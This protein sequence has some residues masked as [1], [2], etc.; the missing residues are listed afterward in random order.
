[1]YKALLPVFAA[2]W[3][4][5]SPIELIAQQTD[6]LHVTL[7][8]RL[9]LANGWLNP[10]T[11]KVGLRGD[12][13]PLTWGTTYLAEDKNHDSLYTVQI[14]F[15]YEGP[16]MQVAL[17]IKVDG[18]KNPDDGWQKG[19]N[20]LITLRKATT[21]TLQLS[22]NDEAAPPPPTLSGDIRIIK[23]FKSQPLQETRDLYI[24]LPP[25]YEKSNR[26]YPV[27]YMHDGQNLFDASAAG[28]E[29]HLDE[30]AESMIKNGEIEPL[31]IVGIGN[32]SQRIDE[33]TPS[34]QVWK[35]TLIRIK[36]TN[37]TGNHKIFT[38]SFVSAQN[39]TIRFKSDTDTLFA[40]IPG[41]SFWQRTIRKDKNVFYLPQAGIT[42][43]FNIGQ[44]NKVDTIYASKPDM[45]GRGKEY[46]A[47][48]INRLKPFIDSTFRTMPNEEHTALGGSSL[49]GLI[50]L[51]AG[52]K[53]PGIFEHLLVLSPS[54]WW[55]NK[56]ILE[57]VR[58]LP[59]ETRQNILLYIG[60]EEGHAIKHVRELYELLLQKGWHKNEIEY[61][62]VKGAG[63]NEKA[64]ASQAKPM[65]KFVDT[66]FT[67]QKR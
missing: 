53:H 47:F 8:M 49:G 6:T 22:W 24:Y 43:K 62:E 18:T 52:L 38:G 27:L 30:T 37:A 54:I 21:D 51:Y 9:P 34:R 20:H 36:P 41:S 17:K 12:V 15:S 26:S 46:T 5:T 31:I 35:R 61:I 23:D 50:S 66:H 65:L 40:K 60:T 11:E 59:E 3:I 14:P 16:E 32:T 58:N 39:D 10:G 1:M 2:L 19:R 42:F 57:V 63:H 28:R 29:W 13:K 25:G 44:E 67:E 7:D 64:W 45:G 56:Y 48:I 55:D 33:Y 4:F